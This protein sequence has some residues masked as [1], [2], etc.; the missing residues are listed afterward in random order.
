M[1]KSPGG[2]WKTVRAGSKEEWIVKGSGRIYWTCPYYRCDR[3]GMLL[4]EGGRLSMPDKASQR[5]YILQY[6]A[7]D[8]GWRRCT[9]ARAVTRHYERLEDEAD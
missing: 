7:H 2:L 5:D 9:V 4:C 6:C 1:W 3:K 8:S